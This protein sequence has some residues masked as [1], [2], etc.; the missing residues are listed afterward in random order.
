MKKWQHDEDK[1]WYWQNIRALVSRLW[2]WR[3]SFKFLTRIFKN[4]FLRKI[5]SCITYYFLIFH[6]IW[7]FIEGTC[8]QRFAG[9]HL[10]CYP[11]VLCYLTRK[12]VYIL[13]ISRIVPLSLIL[14]GLL[15]KSKIF[16]TCWWLDQFVANYWSWSIYFWASGCFEQR[17]QIIWK[18]KIV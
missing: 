18:I 10:I 16:S 4:K 17:I 9:R 12:L 3:R 13:N 1:L 2:N 11:S 5:I 7:R 15:V 6:R 14:E 8:R